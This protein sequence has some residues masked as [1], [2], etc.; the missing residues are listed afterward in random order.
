MNNTPENFMET[1]EGINKYAEGL[2]EMFTMVINNCNKLDP[3]FNT[4]V[5]K[6]KSSQQNSNIFS[7]SFVI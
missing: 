6:R 2:E 1:D 5:S 3:K 7:N 4:N